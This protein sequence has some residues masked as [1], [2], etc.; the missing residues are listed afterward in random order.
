MLT[1]QRLYRGDN[2]AI[3]RQ[4]MMSEAPDLQLP[5]ALKD[6][7]RLAALLRP[8]LAPEPDLRPSLGDFGSALQMLVE[9]WGEAPL[10]ATLSTRL[11]LDPPGLGDLAEEAVADTQMF[12]ERIL[13]DID[14]A[15]PGH[16]PPPPVEVPELCEAAPALALDTPLQDQGYGMQGPPGVRPSSDLH[17]ESVPTKAVARHASIVVVRGKKT[18]VGPPWGRILGGLGALGVVASLVFAGTEAWSRMQQAT[19]QPGVQVA[20]AQWLSAFA[21]FTGSSQDF[22]ASGIKSHLEDS[23]EGYLRARDA[24]K[25]ALILAPEST[26]ALGSYIENEVVGFGDSLL[27]SQRGDYLQWLGPTDRL[28]GAAR[29]AAAQLTYDAADKRR[30]MQDLLQSPSSQDR[31]AGAGLIVDST[32]K[33]ALSA[34]DRDDL[35]A[36]A[37]RV[38]A[39]GLARQGD[40]RAALK[41]L[42]IRQKLEAGNRL[43]MV[44]EAGLWAQAGQMLRAERILAKVVAQA[45]LHPPTLLRHGILAAKL[46][47]TA[48]AASSLKLVAEDTAIEEGLRA[49]AYA[50]WARLGL[51]QQ[52]YPIAEARAQQAHKLR[53]GHGLAVLVAAEARLQ[54]GKP[55][56]AQ[57]AVQAGLT[58][59]PSHFGLGIMNATLQMGEHPAQALAQ[60]ELVA[61]AQ[62]EDPRVA[63]LAASLCLVTGNEA[64]AAMYAGRLSEL[65]PRFADHQDTSVW[66]TPATYQIALEALRLKEGTQARVFVGIL[67]YFYGDSAASKAALRTV[68]EESLARIY[69]AQMWLDRS[70]WARASFTL[71]RA[72]TQAPGIHLLRGRIAAARGAGVKAAA[73]FGEAAGAPGLRHI[74]KMEAAAVLKNTDGL[75]EGLAQRPDD[76]W[77]RAALYRLIR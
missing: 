45:P 65:D 30:L 73:E 40:F 76:G 26:E 69:E 11:G 2:L 18:G 53:P 74:A 12:Y 66:V 42:A 24:L 4:K 59:D 1:G 17:L 15:V 13:E 20:T 62:S 34:L 41:G 36:R 32:H 48:A 58:A 64:R 56:A 46:G 60:I 63:V 49:A 70:A 7:E 55:Q 47:K 44:L 57:Q 33:R 8:C 52:A 39:R 71:A 61:A 5:P 51:A 21:P 72:K 3:L 50:H 16:V 35:P 10:D 14:E 19:A 28:E 6:A 29:R 27:P 68:K 25:K 38:R 43:L 67:H 37:V 23:P 22:L 77:V 54:Q 9:E 31:V 75:R